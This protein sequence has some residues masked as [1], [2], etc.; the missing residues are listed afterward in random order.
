MKIHTPHAHKQVRSRCSDYFYNY[1]TLGVVSFSQKKKNAQRRTVVEGWSTGR[2]GVHRRTDRQT[3]RRTPRWQGSTKSRSD[4]HCVKPGSSLQP[5]VIWDFCVLFAFSTIPLLQD[6]LFDC[7]VHK[8][9]KFIL[10]TNFPGHYN[11]NMWVFLSNF[12][13]LVFAGRSKRQLINLSTDT[14]YINWWEQNCFCTCRYQLEDNTNTTGSKN[15]FQVQVEWKASAHFRV[16][17]VL[18]RYYRC[19]FRIPVVIEKPGAIEGAT[20]LSDSRLITIEAHTKASFFV[21]CSVSLGWARRGHVV[22]SS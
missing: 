4:T 16:C 15:Q 21:C 8:V 11:F 10:H 6:V 3:D 2:G 13:T 20:S 1:V 7:D 12:A 14:F 22:S 5:V 19:D 17:F 9:K 18:C